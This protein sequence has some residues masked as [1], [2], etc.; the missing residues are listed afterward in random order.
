ML[1]L[2]LALA[3]PVDD[4]RAAGIRIH[5][6]KRKE[7][8]ARVAKT[9]GILRGLQ[10]TSLLDVGSG[11]GVFLWPLLDA[12]PDLPVTA[13][14]ILERRVADIHAVAEGG[15]SRL[16]ARLVDTA[17]LP[18]DDG[19]FDVC[20]VLEVLEHLEQPAAAAAE[21]ARAAR[22]FVVASVPSKPDDN[23]EHIRLFARDSLTS[24]F[25]DAGAE[26]VQIQY[27]RGHMIAVVTVAEAA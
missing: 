27:V 4:A 8:P 6:F 16:T 13:I 23:P 1:L 21:I 3:S 10:P 15:E 19:C 9:L 20:T 26:R 22:R 2:G 17:S 12:F 11:R 25:V 24:L 14:D 18:F 5:N 7:G